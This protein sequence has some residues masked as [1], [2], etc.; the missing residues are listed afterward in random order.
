MKSKLLME[1]TLYRLLVREAK[2]AGLTPDELNE[3]FARRC[4][5]VTKK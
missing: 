3:V 1:T 4:M 2:K 5:G